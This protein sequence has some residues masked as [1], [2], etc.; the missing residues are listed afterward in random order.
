MTNEDKI[1][2]LIK[3]AISNGYKFPF[4]DYILER[5]EMMY[6]HTWWASVLF[7]KEFAKALFPEPQAVCDKCFVRNDND[8]HCIG[9]VGLIFE[10]EH[11]IKEAVISENP[12]DYYWENRPIID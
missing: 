9:D 8:C 7:S 1:T 4:T 5:S 2:I 10:W 3:Q 12:I 6:G 11:R